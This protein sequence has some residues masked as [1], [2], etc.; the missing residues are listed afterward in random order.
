MDV[1]EVAVNFADSQHQGDRRKKSQ[2]CNLP[3]NGTI[4]FLFG[5]PPKRIGVVKPILKP[6]RDAEPCLLW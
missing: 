2:Q 4:L 5:Q 3:I 6:T 1:F